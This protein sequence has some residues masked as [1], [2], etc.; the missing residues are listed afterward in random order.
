MVRLLQT[1]EHN[2]KESPKLSAQEL[3]SRELLRGRQRVSRQDGSSYKNC[4]NYLR[5]SADK[6]RNNYNNRS[7]F[8]THGSKQK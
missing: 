4:N 7:K 1:N 3:R 5:I 6:K 2:R 8:P